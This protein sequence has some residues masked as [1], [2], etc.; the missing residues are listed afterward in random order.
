MYNDGAEI[1]KVRREVP[2]SWLANYIEDGRRRQ[3]HPQKRGEKEE[4]EKK[5][6]LFFFFPPSSSFSSSPSLLST[7]T[8]L[9][10]TNVWAGKGHNELALHKTRWK[11][12][13]TTVVVASRYT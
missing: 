3:K 11:I 8:T 13:T 7:S 6:R 1:G 4:E 12:D 10:R 5:C 2:T 9:G